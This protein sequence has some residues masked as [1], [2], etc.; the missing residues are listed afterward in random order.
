MG[1]IIGNAVKADRWI[2][3]STR[4]THPRA[5]E[6]PKPSDMSDIDIPAKKD[7]KASHANTN[8][9]SSHEYLRTTQATN[10]MTGRTSIALLT[11]AMLAILIVVVLIAPSN[12]YTPHS[13]VEIVIEPI[14]ID[15]AFY[16]L[17]LVTIDVCRA[18]TTTDAGLL[19][20]YACSPV[21]TNVSGAS[22]GGCTTSFDNWNRAGFR[23]NVIGVVP[24]DTYTHVMLTF[25][26]VLHV[27]T[28]HTNGVAT[29][30]TLVTFDRPEPGITATRMP[31]RRITI[32]ITTPAI[33]TD[34]TKLTVNYAMRDRVRVSDGLANLNT[35]MY[36]TGDTATTLIDMPEFIAYNS[37]ATTNITYTGTLSNE[38]AYESD[39]ESTCAQFES[40]TIRIVHIEDIGRL[41][42]IIP[43]DPSYN[44]RCI[45]DK[46]C[47]QFVNIEETSIDVL[48]G[49]YYYTFT[50]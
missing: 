31:Y 48:F 2:N 12:K 23:V 7:A 4:H 11:V 1:G 40:A 17:R 6:T 37:V 42:H 34:H 24:H 45:T 36:L 46:S 27:L 18:T 16:G 44:T 47:I 19:I 50:Y 33:V 39:C 8:F 28:T 3:R 38:T 49:G 26:P 21:W 10:T 5:K 35:L 30:S 32:P 15:D 25:D 22:D 20:G 9:S 29:C 13:L 41:V 43:D 14:D